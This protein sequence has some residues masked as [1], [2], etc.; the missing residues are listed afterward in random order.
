[1]IQNK[2]AAQEQA[3]GEEDAQQ[4]PPTGENPFGMLPPEF[5]DLF[6]N[7]PQVP[8]RGIP[9]GEMNNVGSG[10]IIDPSG[11]ILTNNHV[12]QGGG[13]IVVR[14]H[15]GREFKGIE[16][17]TDPKTDLAIVRIKG[18][19]T[20]AATKLGNSDDA[21]VGDWVLALGDPLRTRGH[22]HGG[23]HQRQRPRAGH[24]TTRKTSSKP[25]PPST[26]AIAAAPLVNLDGE[27]VGINTAISSRSGGNQGV[28]FAVSANLAKWVSQQLIAGGDRSSCLSGHRTPAAYART[29]QAV[30][31][32][33]AKRRDRGRGS[34]RKL[35]PPKPM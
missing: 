4:G 34:S 1:M 8:H 21:Q 22:R 26:P 33:F 35:Q 18:A 28:G 30:R 15:D 3:E 14:L 7:M 31:C 6:K 32:P 5:R 19:G 29:G 17:K 27:I 20:L 11:I 16:V 23:H 13:E 12:V 24:R 10:V 25:T 2:P 9:R